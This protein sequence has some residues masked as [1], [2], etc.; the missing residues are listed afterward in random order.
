[1]GEN[2]RQRAPVF[3]EVNSTL[4]PENF[5]LS[6]T[7]W[8]EQCRKTPPIPLGSS[9]SG[10]TVLLTWFAQLGRIAS[11]LKALLLVAT[12]D[13][14]GALWTQPLLRVLVVMVEHAGEC[15]LVSLVIVY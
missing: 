10:K 7:S 14:S 3:E 12:L 2:K 1:M 4:I 15:F 13:C 8:L 9:V 5:G 6:H 11:T